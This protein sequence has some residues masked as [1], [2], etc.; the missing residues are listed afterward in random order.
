MAQAHYDIVIVGAGP[1]G[2]NFARLL[3]SKKR[4]LL[5]DGS[6]E[7]PKVCAGLLSPDA[8]RYLKRNELSLPKEI[9]C[10]PQLASVRVIDLNRNTSRHY[11]RRLVGF[12]LALAKNVVWQNWY[13]FDRTRQDGAEFEDFARTQINFSF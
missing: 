3:V 8:V 11:P 1:A 4:I 5:I 9:L 7:H 10:D 6:H 13:A 12:D 2:C